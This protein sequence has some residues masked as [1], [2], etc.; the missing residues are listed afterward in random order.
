MKKNI[1]MLLVLSLMLTLAVG[2]FAAPDIE[3]LII[4]ASAGNSQA[5]KDL[6]MAYFEGSVLSKNYSKALEWLQKAANAGETDCYYTIGTIYEKGG[7]GVQK[8]VDEAMRWYN[9]AADLGDEDAKLKLGLVTKKSE[10]VF[11]VK[12]SEP[13]WIRLDGVFGEPEIVR[14]GENAGLANPFYLDS[15]VQNCRHVKLSLAVTQKQGICTGYYYLYVKDTE[16]K[17]HHT[18][19]F[20]LR[21]FHINGDPVVFDLD[22]DT[23]ETFVAVALWPADKGM[24]FTAIYDYAVYVDPACI[25]EYSSKI[26]KPNFTVSD[27]NCAVIS[28]H[29][30]TQAYKNPYAAFQ[31]FIQDFVY[32]GRNGDVWVDIGGAYDQTEHDRLHPSEIY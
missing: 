30:K 32:V 27:V 25:A 14:T 31:D 16:G 18:A 15:P 11:T 26:P 21:D 1:A 4:E 10:P 8:D 5:M 2:A 20:R 23:N 29:F 28:L 19:V 9:K 7:D 6:G 22:L 3:N 12:N 24:D 13:A 17:W